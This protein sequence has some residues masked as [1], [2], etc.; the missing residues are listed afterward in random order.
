[1][2][3]FGTDLSSPCRTNVATVASSPLNSGS[4]R[5]IIPVPATATPREPVHELEPSAFRSKVAVPVNGDGGAIV[6]EVRASSQTKSPLG[7]AAET[8][9]MIEILWEFSMARY[10]NR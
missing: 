9:R 7:P 3:Y 10:R 8:T 2:S 4:R 5:G 6:A 1:M